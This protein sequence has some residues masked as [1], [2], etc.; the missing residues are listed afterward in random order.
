[1]RTGA[2]ERPHRVTWQNGVTAPDGGGSYTQTWTDCAPPSTS[3]KI[4]AAT[5]QTLER[6]RAGTTVSA[7]T[8]VITGPYHPQITTKSRALYNGRFFSVT[9]VDNVDEANVT[10]VAVC[11]EVVP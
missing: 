9:G 11:V 7:A 2:G 3:C 8:H 10:T 5:A 1:M 6:V 4:E